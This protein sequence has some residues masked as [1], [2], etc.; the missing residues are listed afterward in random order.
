MNCAF[1]FVANEA[2]PEFFRKSRGRTG[3]FVATALFLHR[4][5]VRRS[6]FAQ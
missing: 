5:P 6:G 3:T 1:S 4:G 2:D